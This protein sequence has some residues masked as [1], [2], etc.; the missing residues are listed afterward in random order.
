MIATYV[1]A[2]HISRKLCQ[3]AIT[4]RLMSQMYSCEK[5]LNVFT[6]FYM[7]YCG[8]FAVICSVD[9]VQW[10]VLQI[11]CYLISIQKTDKMHFSCVLI[12]L[13]GPEPDSET[14]IV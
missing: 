4:R 5:D 8:Y 13:N 3:T 2:A 1:A 14:W 9:C 7:L 12:V 6:L 10:M 11:M